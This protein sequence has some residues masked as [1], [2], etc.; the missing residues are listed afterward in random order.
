MCD[1]VPD[2]AVEVYGPMNDLAICEIL[3]PV[4]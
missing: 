4:G 2:R 3:S 1:T